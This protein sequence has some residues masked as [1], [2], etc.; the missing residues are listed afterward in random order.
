LSACTSIPK[1]DL[2]QAR[3]ADLVCSDLDSEVAVSQKSIAVAT[4]AKND[5][6]RIIFPTLIALRYAGASFE[7]T[8]A[9]NRLVK[10]QEEQ[11]LKNCVP[12]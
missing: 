9:Q 7:L 4:G 3:F 6:W 2:P 10:L 5:A 8:N 11:K 1:S 12:G